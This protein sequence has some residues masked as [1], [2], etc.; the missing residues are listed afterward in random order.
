MP[1]HQ[2]A[3]RHSNPSAARNAI[4]RSRLQVERL[5]DRTTP[6]VFMVTS[7]SGDV[8][9]GSF[10]Q[11][12]LDANANSGLDEIHFNIPGTGVQT[13]DNIAVGTLRITDAVV[14][15]GYT[16]PGASANTLAQGTNAVLLIQLD[17]W[18]A[19][20]T[21]SDGLWVEANNCII[22]GLVMSGFGGAVRIQ[23]S[24]NRI[25]GNFLGTD[26]TGTVEASPFIA[27]AS[28]RANSV[29]VK[30]DLGQGNVIGGTD[31][32]ARNLIS[33]NTYGI[34]LQ[35][36]GYDPL[37]G[38]IIQGNLIG[39]DATGTNALG[40]LIG[41]QINNATG[42]LIGGTT[43]AARNIISGQEH[44]AGILV[45]PDVVGTTIQGN[46]IGTDVTGTKALPN[47]TGVELRGTGATVGGTA[48]GA[49]NVISGSILAGIFID[50]MQ[51]GQH[52]IQGN[53]I[54]TDYTGVNDLGNQ[55]YGIA[56]FGP[57]DNTIGGQEE[58][59]GNIIAFSGEYAVFVTP[60]AGGG[61]GNGNLIDPNRIFGSGKHGIELVGGA[62]RGQ[63]SPQLTFARYANGTI[64]IR[65]TLQ[66]T[67]NATFLLEFFGNDMLSDLG[68]AE[69]EHFLG[70]TYVTTDASG[71]AEFTVSFATAHPGSLV[72][73]TAT[74]PTN[75]TSEFSSPASVLVADPSHVPSFTAYAP[76]FRGGVGVAT[77]DIDGDGHDEVI[78]VAGAGAGPH[79]VAFDGATGAVLASFLAYA[80]GFMGGVNVVLGDLDGDGTAEI[81]TG[82]G[83]GVG[84]HVKAFRYSNGQIQEMASF[85]AY[86]PDFMGGVQVAVGDLD[87]DGNSE[88]VTGA[89]AGA[90]PHV[91]AF[92]YSDGQITEVASFY[93]YDANF[94][95]GVRVAVGDLDG[96]GRSEIV[97]GAG[98]GAGPHVK[99]FQL[100][101]GQITE[102]TSFFAFSPEFLGGVHVTTGDIDGDGK[103]E[104]IAQAMTGAGPHVKA[105]RYL[106]VQITEV[107]SFMVSNLPSPDGS[108]G[109]APKTPQTEFPGMGLGIAVGDLNGDGKSE[110]VVGAELGG[111]P[112]VKIFDPFDLL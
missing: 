9:P 14:I 96:D 101:S 88:I 2:K 111:T 104:I 61:D 87:G 95:G 35:G 59:A 89:G 28:P 65:G 72:T 62:N 8:V 30:V 21:K 32:A 82:T 60:K 18:V 75:D 29:G 108:S 25:E 106:G 55:H 52:V 98:P 46:Y 43:A 12:I 11:A 23:G 86:S 91:K 99:A 107:A 42:T 109:D 3:S 73:S 49:G 105:F 102:V 36:N 80:P 10:S 47:S 54:G 19:T 110:L 41:I 4:R 84:A 58:G 53:K 69:G 50:V 27:G 56:I 92:R 40:N 51:A 1:T 94:P 71:R 48:P 76:E 81:I 63:L 38:T 64:T 6:T 37:D 97:T 13:I 17:G 90:G 93:A 39:T 33:G 16:Q 66:S 100:A 79:I 45:A 44:A 7:D 83:A 74:S 103:D 57:D 31:P 70:H 24:N 20:N 78:T 34:H 68:I 77:G 26:P 67:P 112:L 15:D 5:E 85:F 22:R